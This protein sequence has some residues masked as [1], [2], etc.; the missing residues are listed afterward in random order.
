MKRLR[1]MVAIPALAV[2]A[3]AARAQPVRAI[4]SGTTAPASE[5]I[6]ITT[7]EG[8]A[9][10]VDL[11]RD[12]H[13]IVF[14]LLGEIW[15]LDSAG[16]QARAITDAVRDTAENLDPTLSPDGRQIVFSGER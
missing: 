10:S 14:D 12:G 13:T 8:T 7:R 11:S 4:S 16:G 15:I 2:G 9:L 6:S 1:I 3:A 5:T